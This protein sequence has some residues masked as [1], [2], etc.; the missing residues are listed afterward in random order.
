MDEKKKAK[1]LRRKLELQKEKLRRECREDVNKFIEWVARDDKGQR[2]RQGAIHRAMHE[3]LD[4]YDRAQIEIPRGHGKSVQVSELRVAWEIG[5]NPNIFIKILCQDDDFAMKRLGAIQKLLESQEYLAIF[6]DVEPDKESGWS[7]SKC[8]VKRAVISPNP[9]IEACGILG[10][11]AGGRAHLIIADDVC[12]IRNTILN[13]ALKSK[14]KSAYFGTWS[15]QL[16]PGGRMWYIDTPYHETDL[17]R[18]IFANKR[19]HT[20]TFRID[21][22]QPIWPEYW[23]EAELQAKKI[24]IGHREYARAY[25]MRVL[26]DEEM[27]FKKHWMQYYDPREAT[28]GKR[29]WFYQAVDPAIGEDTDND[30]F[31]HITVAVDRDFNIY[32]V[33]MVRGRFSFETQIDLCISQFIKWENVIKLGIEKTAYQRVLPQFLA[34]KDYARV[35]KSSIIQ[36]KADKNKTFRA[37]RLSSYFERKMVWLH[38]DYP[39][40]EEELLIFCR[41]VK[42][43]RDDIMDALGYACELVMEYGISRGSGLGKDNMGKITQNKYLSEILKNV[44]IKGRGMVPKTDGINMAPGLT[45]KNATHNWLDKMLKEIK[46]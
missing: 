41:N 7:K 5:R 6:P 23:T 27:V 8:Y 43:Q 1:L 20:L 4:L 32:L 38:P 10:S 37:E 21:N 11:G 3:H 14:V 17:S 42:E 28:R 29:L 45:F 12:D 46:K 19:Y 36:V 26:S 30:F 24:E 16:I 22:F 25:E 18:D 33:D 44:Q 31:V 34:R 35:F 13:P 2:I 39:E 40:V 9:T 15:N